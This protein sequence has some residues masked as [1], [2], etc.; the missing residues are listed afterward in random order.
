[1]EIAVT[2]YETGSPF[3]QGSQKL[4]AWRNLCENFTEE[5]F[6]IMLSIVRNEG[7]DPAV[8]LNGCKSLME[9]RWGKAP[10]SVEISSDD[11]ML[12]SLMSHEQLMLAAEAQT[13]ALV[14][15][16][17]QSG[18]LDEI[19]RRYEGVVPKRIEK[20]ITEVKDDRLVTKPK[21]KPKR[22]AS[23]MTVNVKPKKPS[24]KKSD[25]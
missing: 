1:M 14:C 4:N 8:R 9:A 15:S 12:P 17:I 25:R 7:V 23:A 5:A 16:L 13:E 24:R 20:D 11:L 19:V 2:R 3:K 21:A 18:K 22:E 10:Q 6:G